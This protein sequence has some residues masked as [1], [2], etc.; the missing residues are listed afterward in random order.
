MESIWNEQK[1]YGCL[2]EKSALGNDW[3]YCLYVQALKLKH[4][5][6]EDTE[7]SVIREWKNGDEVFFLSHYWNNVGLIRGKFMV[8]GKLL[9]KL[10][11]TTR[12]QM[13]TFFYRICKQDWF[14]EV[15]CGL[16]I[17]KSLITKK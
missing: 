3:S 17:C 9:E 14:V 12:S 5:D 6:L 11:E 10:L 7:E 16:W 1:I 8:E 13:D 2:I 15:I 4:L